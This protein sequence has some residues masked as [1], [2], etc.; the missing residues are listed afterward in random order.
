MGSLLRDNRATI[1]TAAIIAG[2]LAVLWLTLGP[3]S[4]P[5]QALVALVH[6]SDGQV[7]ELPL[8]E[9]ARLEVTTELGTNVIVVEDG[10]V[11][12]ADA[13]CPNRTCLQVQPLSAPGSQIICLP[14]QLW[15]EV[16]PEG[17]AGGAMDVSLAEDLGDD[18]DLQAR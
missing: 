18:I 12:M 3:H 9:D 17:E 11:R 16:V 6:D 13:D 15:I 4:A 8:S 1:I 5:D 10:E 14:H 7:H 2:V